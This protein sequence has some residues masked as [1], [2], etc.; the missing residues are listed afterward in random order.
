M[1]NSRQNPTPTS[2]TIEA[3]LAALLSNENQSQNSYFVFGNLYVNNQGE[4][5]EDKEAKESVPEIELSKIFNDLNLELN[6]LAKEMTLMKNELKAVLEI[7][8]KLK[9]DENDSVFVFGR[10]NE[11]NGFKFMLKPIPM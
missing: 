2:N 10:S 9:D 3:A 7:K 11:D 6:N 5:S 1:D 4:K 8:G